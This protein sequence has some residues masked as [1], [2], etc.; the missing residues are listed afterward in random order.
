[1]IQRG[2]YSSR[3]CFRFPVVNIIVTSQQTQR[4]YARGAQE[5]SV[6][7]E[8]QGRGV[9][10]QLRLRLRLSSGTRGLFDIDLETQ[11]F[12]ICRFATS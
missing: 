6:T 10:S 11:E 12:V 2:L 1:M 8:G 4:S 7:Q 9:C 5:L 3:G